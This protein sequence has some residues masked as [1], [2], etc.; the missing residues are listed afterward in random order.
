MKDLNHIL[1]HPY[2]IAFKT[3]LKEGSPKLIIPLINAMFHPKIPLDEHA[4]IERLSNEL[5]LPGGKKEKITDS[6]LRINDILWHMECD[7]YAGDKIVAQMAEYDLYTGL[8]NARLNI[9]NAG[10]KDPYTVS[11]PVSGVLFLRKPSHRNLIV[12]IKTSKTELLYRINTL[13]LQDYTLEELCYKDLYI[14]IPFYL[15]NHEKDIEKYNRDK[16]SCK[17]VKDAMH[18]MMHALNKAYKSEQILLFDYRTV[19]VMMK[20][21]TEGLAMDNEEMRK[22][23]DEIMSEGTLRIPGKEYYLRVRKECLSE[24]IDK[25]INETKQNV[26]LNMLADGKLSIDDISKYSGLSKEEVENLKH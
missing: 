12:S 25:G 19:T 9:K 18:Q 26:A 2:D 8:N 20:T 15:F 6:Q 21:V 7:C 24:G 13:I 22:D 3:G 11:L 17:R 16:A 5:I 14:L 10:S 23:L 1:S 4:S